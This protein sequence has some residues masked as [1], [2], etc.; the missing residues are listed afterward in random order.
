MKTFESFIPS[1]LVVQSGWNLDTLIYASLF[2]IFNP[3]TVWIFYFTEKV[4]GRYATAITIFWVCRYLNRCMRKSYATPSTNKLVL[5]SGGASGLGSELVKKWSSQKDIGKIIVVDVQKPDKKTGCG[6]DKIHYI[7]YDLNDTSLRF[8]KTQN[9]IEHCDDFVDLSKV[10][11]LVCNAGIRQMQTL[12]ELQAE[13]IRKISHVNW[14][15][16]M[17][18]IKQYIEAISSREKSRRFQVVV[19][20]SVLGFVGPKQLGIYAGTKNAL[21]SLMDSLR[22]ELPSNIVLSTVLPGQLD[23]SMF[24]DVSVN[25]FLAPIIHTKKLAE[26]IHTIVEEGWNGTFSYPTYGRL[27]PIYRVLP[28]W[29]QRFCRWFSGMDDV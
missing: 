21:M 13:E 10:D 11:I 12:Q 19:V 5:I 22:E 24:A 18:L 7:Q 15:S 4:S 14:L 3:I 8:L 23:S 20:G 9:G 1:P 2:T 26:R 27:L 6:C 17:L 16:H 28:W 25:H 29:A